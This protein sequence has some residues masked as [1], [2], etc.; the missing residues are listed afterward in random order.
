[1]IAVAIF[2]LFLTETVLC[3]NACTLTQPDI[4][5]PYWIPGSPTK[6][7]AVCDNLPAHDV[8]VLT[9]RVLDFDSKCGKG[10][11]N[12]KL[13]IW[14]ANMQGVY[15]AGK[16]SADWYCRAIIFPDNDGNFKIS[17]LFPGRYDD[18]GYRPAHIHFNVTAPGYPQLVTQLYFKQDTYLSPRDSCQRCRSDSQS[19]IATVTHVND[20]K[21]YVGNWDI[22][23]SKTTR[24]R[25]VTKSS[26]VRG[27]YVDI[28]PHIMQ[29]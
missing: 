29:I 8:L 13:D 26:V 22:V 1:M 4:L 14:Q 9:G 7:D 10:I 20:I 5:G 17:T 16:S 27:S 2:L 25:I 28:K 18:G 19:L 21:T 15:S 6:K 12:V 3:Q 23:L 11:S 24:P